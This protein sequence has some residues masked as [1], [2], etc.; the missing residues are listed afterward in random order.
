MKYLKVID[1]YILII[2]N[3]LTTNFVKTQTISG[4]YRIYLTDKAYNEYNINNPETFL[5]EKSIQRRKKFKIPIDTRDLPVSNYYIDSLKKLGLEI[6]TTSKWMNTIVVGPINDTLK[7]KLDSIKFIKYYKKVAP[8]NIALTKTI[9][10]YDKSE[11]GYSYNQIKLHNG[12]ILHKYGYTGKN[13]YIAVIDAGFKNADKISSLQHLWQEKKIIAIKDFSRPISNNILEEDSHGTMVL[14]ILAGKEKNKYIGTAPDSYYLLLR[15]ENVN[16]EYSIEEDYWI[17]AV[18]FADS[19]GVDIISTSLGYN[20]FEDPTQNYVVDDMNGKTTFISK[21][22]SI[23]SSKGILV[24]VSAGNTGNSTWKIITTP[25]DADSILAVGAID[26]TGNIAYFSGRG[27]TADGRIKPDVCSIGYMTYLQAPDN[28]IRKSNGTSFSTPIISGLSACLWQAFPEIDN[29]KLINTIKKSS[30]KYNNPDNNYGYGIPDFF[31]AYMILKLENTQFEDHSVLLYP[32]P[33]NDYLQIFLKWNC[34]ST[35][36]LNIYTLEGKLIYNDKIEI[37][38][39]YSI[40]TLT[41]P[42]NLKIGIYLL[43]IKDQ[44][45]KRIFKLIK[46]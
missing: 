46:R 44:K 32:N 15:S 42:E 28:T 6:I 29:I 38:E 34:P 21:G 36:N 11:Y 20:I 33:V 12:D 4:F 30:N 14:S 26:S 22:A 23:A 13:I 17:A 8:L 19:I 27:P 37:F 3:I 10:D 43:E 2:F 18:E 25:A 24:V 31:K 35:I 39:N 41:L 40:I 7:I 1:I 45:N 5:S 9:V 16:Y